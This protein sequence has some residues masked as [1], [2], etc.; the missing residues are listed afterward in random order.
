LLYPLIVFVFS[1]VDDIVLDYLT[2]V[3]EG[4]AEDDSTN[5]EDFID[6]MNAYIPGF[7]DLHRYTQVF[8]IFFKTLSDRSRSLFPNLS[9][10]KLQSLFNK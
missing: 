10:S 4:L 3:L 2:G 5:I 8:I 7:S 9:S 6:M 1:V